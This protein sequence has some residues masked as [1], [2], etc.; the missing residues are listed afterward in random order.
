[1]NDKEITKWVKSTAERLVA[2]DLAERL[3]NRPSIASLN[4]HP[5]KA[6][7]FFE[8]DGFLA[9]LEAIECDL[10]S[11]YDRLASLRNHFARGEMQPYHYSAKP[12]SDSCE[13]AIKALT[14][15]KN[16]KQS[17]AFEHPP[18][19]RALYLQKWATIEAAGLVGASD[20]RV[21]SIAKRL[22][23]EAR[24]SE[25]STAAMRRWLAEYRGKC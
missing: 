18:K 4:G 3:D 21:C 10:Q 16:A 7:C 23:L 17:A 5:D 1:M 24:I 6:S 15:V 20:R 22:M 19:T 14:D 12:L 11:A 13:Y 25:P 8:Y 9:E 2:L